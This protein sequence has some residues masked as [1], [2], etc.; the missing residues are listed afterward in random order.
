MQQVAMYC[1]V[2]IVTLPSPSP[3]I[4]ILILLIAVRK[5]SL[6]YS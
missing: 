3:S 2:A 4:L 6:E 5:M 1:N